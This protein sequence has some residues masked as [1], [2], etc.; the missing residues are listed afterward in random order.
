MAR[1][2]KTLRIKGGEKENF[3]GCPGCIHEEDSEEICRLRL[4]VHAF[5][6]FE[7]HYEPKE[8]AD[9]RSKDPQN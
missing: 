8:K 4:C 3:I 9:G 1:Y 2:E 7:D 5:N 6:Y